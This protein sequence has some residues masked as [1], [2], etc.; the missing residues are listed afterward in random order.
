MSKSE[1]GGLLAEDEPSP[2]DSLREDGRS[3]YFLICDHAGRRLPRALGSLGLSQAALESHIAWDIGSGDLALCLSAMLDA[4]LVM[5]RY[6]RLVIDCNRPPGAADSIVALSEWTEVPG[7]A[8][9]SKE[10]AEAR[11]NQIFHPYHAKIRNELDR[12]ERQGRQTLLVTLHSF[13]PT[14][15]NV[16]RPWHV[17]ILHNRDARLARPLLDL[18]RRETGLSVGDNEPYAAGELTDFSLVSHGERRG[19]PTVEIEV[20]QDLLGDDAGRATW[21]ERFARIFR[22]LSEAQPQVDGFAAGAP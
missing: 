12:R 17:G 4:T 2:F 21:A 7:N 15:K 1:S 19:I 13:T 11:E 22:E 8:A 16:A 3:P 9:I 6:S 18:L 14:F 5:Q 20:R 10:D